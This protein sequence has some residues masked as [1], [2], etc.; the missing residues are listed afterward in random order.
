[1]DPT[2]LESQLVELIRRASTVLPP[3][4]VKAIEQGYKREQAGTPAKGA[5]KTILSSVK[6]SNQ[7]SLPVCQ[8][9]G[10]HIWYVYYPDGEK[11]GPVRKA[12][13]KAVA[14]ATS[15]NYLRPN[16]VDSVTGENPGNNLGNG[17]LAVH[18]RPW[19]K[20]SWTFDLMLKG[21][22]CENVS[23]QMKLPDTNL[24]AGRD[25]DGV[26]K[27]VM[28]MIY[29]AQGRGCAPGVA[30]IGIGGVRDSSMSLAKQQ[31]YRKL[32]DV[33]PDSDLAKLEK[34]LYADINKLGIGPMGYGGKTTVLGVKIG[35]YHR[36]P[37]T[38][39]VSLAYMC[40]ADRRCKMTL[41][42]KKIKYDQ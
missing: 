42:G 34:K 26:Y 19:N 15:L 3:D 14:K 5:M 8:D 20:K 38:F 27:A 23:G 16:S 28:K 41:S 4:V 39:Y 12:I 18:F 32:E 31:I 29:D 33:N 30:C 36:H 21:G 25:L 2:K 22:G 11:L 17:A 10:A 24:G 7:K 37:A 13:E 35:K 1:V 6:L 40:W 9:T